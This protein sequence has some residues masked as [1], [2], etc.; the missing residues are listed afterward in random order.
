MFD[1]FFS[2]KED[3]TGLGLSV[4]HGI[5]EKHGGKISVESA[6]DKGTCFEI[7]LPFSRRSE[8]K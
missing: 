8:I 7:A 4:V 2:K 1:P 3:G 6:P 5:I